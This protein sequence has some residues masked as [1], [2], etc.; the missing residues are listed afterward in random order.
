MAANLSDFFSIATLNCCGISHQE[1][2]SKIREKIKNLEIVCL[3]E[4]H[5]KNDQQSECFD[6]VLGQSFFILHSFAEPTNQKTGISFLVNRNFAC[7]TMK[8]DFEIQGRALGISLS[9]G[10]K[11][12]WIVG[13]YAPSNATVRKEFYTTLYNAIYA[14][15]WY[16]N[17]AHCVIGDFNVVENPQIDRS[18]VRYDNQEGVEQLNRITDFLS[19][20]DI[21]R[22]HHPNTNDFFTFFSKIWNTQSRLDRIYVSLNL[23]HGSL[24]TTRAVSMTDHR[25]FRAK[26]KHLSAM[27]KRGP[28]Y[29][30]INTL[31]LVKNDVYLR[32]YFVHRIDNLLTLNQCNLFAGWEDFKLEVKDYFQRL[33]K[34]KAKS[35]NM[36]RKALE[37]SI[38][39]IYSLITKFPAESEN[40]KKLLKTKHQELDNIDSFYL[41]TCR[42][43]TYYKDFV[44]DKISISTAKSLQRKDWENRHI[45]QIR[46]EDGTLVD[47]PDR[48]LNV[49][50]K[51][52]SSLYETHGVS[53]IAF[54][55]IV[56]R[57]HI[58]KLIEMD[59][60]M[61]EQKI[62]VDEVTQAIQATKGGKTPGFDG[63]PIE[64][65]WLFSEKLSIFLCKL[66]NFFVTNG[67][68]HS[69]AYIGI[70]S[71]L[72]KGAGDR[73]MR[74]NWRPLTM[75]NL[76]YKIFT[77]ILSRRLR[78][79]I[80]TIVHPDQTCG[81]PGRKI[82]DS[83][84]HLMSVL[85]YCNEFPSDVCLLSVDHL[86]AFDLIEWAY[87]IKVLEHMNFGEKFINTIKC[88]YKMGETKSSV[89]VNG[90]ISPFFEV[91]RGI[92]QGCPLSPLLYVIATELVANF[93]RQTPLLKGIPLYGINTRITK[94]ADD[95]SIFIRSWDEIAKVFDIFELFELASGSKLK[96]EKTQLLQ[97]GSFVNK[98]VPIRYEIFITKKLKLYGH[99]I[100][101]EGM[102]DDENW[103]K[104]RNTIE[105]LASKMPPFGISPFGKIH[106]VYIYYLCMFNYL[107]NVITPP[108]DLLKSAEKNII[109]FL[110]YPA[111]L[112][113]IK[114]GV[115]KLPPD[116][117]GIGFPDLRI[118]IAVNRVCF[119]ARVLSSKEELSWRRAFFHFYGRVEFLSKIQ[120]GQ[121]GEN[122]KYI[123]KFYREIRLAVIET[124]FRRDGDF[125]WYF[126]KKVA[127][128]N[129]APKN[130]Y[131]K[132]IEVKF[133]PLME[134]RNYFW[135]QHLGVDPNYVR[136]SWKWA[137]ASHTYGLARDTHFK[138]RHRA[139]FTKHKSCHILGGDNFCTL[140]AR[141]GNFVKE[142]NLHL[143]LGCPRATGI[144][145][146]MTPILCRIAGT[147]TID[148]ADLILG[149]KINE[150]S[151]QN[152]FNF[153]IQ[154]IQLAIWQARKNEE[155]LNGETDVFTLLKTN[156]F[157]NLYRVKAVTQEKIFFQKFNMITIP[158]DTVVGF[159][160]SL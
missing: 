47:E 77:K 16:E 71:L 29:F 50:C 88:I 95:T 90:F 75:L 55:H 40:L 119:F 7:G 6:R 105:K 64:F 133:S 120:V 144:Y 5:F 56:S 1:K 41:A 110:W 20:H 141:N 67:R 27:C 102:N 14:S 96:K 3:Q 57:C 19:L 147:N 115:L 81:V 85:D 131:Q 46:T 31:L 87:I 9:L 32:N 118:R 28:S 146:R 156:L 103:E 35:R 43:N 48:I 53:D 126:G 108:N 72:Y 151:K 26:F 124:S 153:L 80:A 129:L 36:E 21:Y 45:H 143:L 117:G 107:S 140:C 101:H 157:R 82:N 142:D 49:V 38:R 155:N 30:K 99:L 134:E 86:A 65:F 63:I 74:E 70:I 17:D 123:P 37:T 121:L 138:I 66:F 130:L 34:Q 148:R 160:V 79:V 84:Y 18:V 15:K 54:D 42:H 61:L 91:Q 59:S 106:S 100:T 60:Q 128:K 104:S 52:Y 2:V 93:I 94:Y 58:P 114:R 135:A 154:N 51:Q 109:K 150:K 83:V 10:G 62:T 122:F 145:Q 116:M 127:L 158:I 132:W 92:R 25:L 13:I 44:D 68:M 78:K 137:K 76:D 149:K 111:K 139:L 98:P 8:Q 12:V 24:C 159:R 89:Q 152:C 73:S 11:S 97:L 39:K 125:C 22:F 23:T 112:D 113:I 33:G 69:S 4:T 136:L